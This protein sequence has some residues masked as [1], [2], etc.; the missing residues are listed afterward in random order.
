MS[1]IEINCK[2]ALNRVSGPYPYSWDL[3]I[4]RGC[5]HGCKYCYAL[6]SHKYLEGKEFYSNVY[7]KTNIIPILDRELSRHRKDE[8]VNIGSVCDSYQPLEHK[9]QLMPQVLELFIKYEIPVIISSKSDMILRDI[10]LIARLNKVAYTNIAA[11]VLTMDEALARKIEPGAVAPMRR[12]TMLKEIKNKTG[13]FTGLHCMPILPFIT[14]DYE[15]LDRVFAAAS[16]AGVDYVLA[17]GMNMRG[18][19][20]E[21]YSAFVKQAFP[22]VY[23]QFHALARPDLRKAYKQNMAQVLR[24]LYEKHGLT[25][26]Y[27]K[28][29]RT[30]KNRQLTIFD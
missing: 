2:T 5:T 4:Y 23:D 18:E 22:Q 25:S 6:Y 29:I 30:A 13:V 21:K 17:G 20:G 14:N 19:T 11:S 24:S 26:D 27:H 15:N 8:I 1:V 10:D 3:N 12:V 9:F 28:N 16:A 7:V